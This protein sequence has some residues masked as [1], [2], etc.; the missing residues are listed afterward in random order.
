VAS[1]C[2]KYDLTAITAATENLLDVSI[3]SSFPPLSPDLLVQKVRVETS[4]CVLIS[5]PGDSPGDAEV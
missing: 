4:N 5:S 2:L 3:H 1:F